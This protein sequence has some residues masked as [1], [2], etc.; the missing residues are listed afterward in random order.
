MIVPA[1]PPGRNAANKCRR[2]RNIRPSVQETQHEEYTVHGIIPNIYS[3]YNGGWAG[4]IRF[5]FSNARV[6]L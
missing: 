5:E 4:D 3:S 6:G 2:Y 1:F